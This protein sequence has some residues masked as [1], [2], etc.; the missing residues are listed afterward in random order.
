MEHFIERFQRMTGI[1]LV[2][3]KQIITK[4]G[5]NY[6]D[7]ALISSVAHQMNTIHFA[8]G[9]MLYLMAKE[10]H[11]TKHRIKLLDMA[12]SKLVLSL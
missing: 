4:I 5:I 12:E 3:P 9:A 11:A 7:I 1:R 10:N 6:T 8:E 2:S